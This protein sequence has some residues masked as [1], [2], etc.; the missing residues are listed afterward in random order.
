MGNNGNN[1]YLYRKCPKLVRPQ[2]QYCTLTGTTKRPTTIKHNPTRVMGGRSHTRYGRGCQM[3]RQPKPPF[4]VFAKARKIIGEGGEPERLYRSVKKC[5]HSSYGTA[6]DEAPHYHTTT[7]IRGEG[8]REGHAHAR[9][10]PVKARR[11][12]PTKPSLSM[13]RK[14]RERKRSVR[15][16]GDVHTSFW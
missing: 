10:G 1:G 15:R 3:R 14:T 5:V 2:V 7:T 16:T 8:G 11:Q 9:E 13:R 6:Y 4:F 12:P